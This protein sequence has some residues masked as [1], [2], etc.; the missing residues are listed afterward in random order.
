[1]Y[2]KYLLYTKVCESTPQNRLLVSLSN[3]DTIIQNDEPNQPHF[4]KR[5]R[6]FIAENPYYIT[7]MR[8]QVGNRGMVDLPKGAKYYY[9]MLGK[10]GNV[11]ETA[12]NSVKIGY[13]NDESTIHATELNERGQKHIEIPF[14]KGGFGVIPNY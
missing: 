14:K 9:F 1:M 2:E 3:G 10:H 7:M 13:A 11:G 6:A 5:L 12:F 8:F 4:W